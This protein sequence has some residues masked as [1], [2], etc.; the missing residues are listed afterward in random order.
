MDGSTRRL[1][2]IILAIMLS[3]SA[4]KMEPR[5]DASDIPMLKKML[6][7]DDEIKRAKASAALGSI[8]TE[9][10]PVLR[11]AAK[12]TDPKIREWGIYGISKIC[13]QAPEVKP[14]LIE[15]LNDE[16]MPVRY[17][18]VRALGAMGAGAQDALPVMIKAANDEDWRMRY[19]VTHQLGWI[20]S[21]EECIDFLLEGMESE[22]YVIREQAVRAL[23]YWDIDA[24]K[25]LPALY[26]AAVYEEPAIQYTAVKAIRRIGT[27][28]EYIPEIIDV[29]HDGEFLADNQDVDLPDKFSYDLM[30]TLKQGLVNEDAETRAKTA[31]IIGS[32]GLRGAEAVNVLIETLDDSNRDV[33]HSVVIALG[34]IGPPARDAIPILEKMLEHDKWGFAGEI[35]SAI[36]NI[37]VEG[38]EE[39]Q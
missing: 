9:A 36:E 4:C 28:D 2:V 20:C 12:D 27:D 10:L 8:G 26:K 3:V 6:Y 39:D 15:A 14:L 37:G 17:E 38:K 24:G 35:H 32:M 34:S 5:Y 29:L 23:A 13:Y 22:R 19:I 7:G 21:T 16:A 33:V 18:A 11:V 30:S 25:A 31:K 1:I